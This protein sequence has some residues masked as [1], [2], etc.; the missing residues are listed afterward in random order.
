MFLR[1]FPV[2][3][4]SLFERPSIWSS[5]RHVPLQYC[6]FFVLL[7]PMKF[8][9][10]H[11]SLAQPWYFP[12]CLMLDLTRSTCVLQTRGIFCVVF[13][14][15][16]EPRDNVIDL[17]SRLVAGM[18]LLLFC[19]VP[20]MILQI[21]QVHLSLFGVLLVYLPVAA[22][23]HAIIPRGW[24]R[25]PLCATTGLAALAGFSVTQRALARFLPVIQL[26]LDLG[27]LDFHFSTQSKMTCGRDH[28]MG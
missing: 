3:V 25:N 21:S 27:G 19:S 22:R 23:N 14:V 5:V 17:T 28:D 13:L 10:T 4:L 18:G 8:S 15:T 20:E 1:T 2:K 26:A 6:S 16:F 11:S 9:D 12:A 24:T 7:K